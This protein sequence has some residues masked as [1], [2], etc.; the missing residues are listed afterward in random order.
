MHARRDDPAG[1][2]TSGRDAVV[3]PS[4]GEETDLSAARSPRYVAIITDG[5]RRWA[6]ARGLSM[7]E[8]HDA[9]ASTVRATWS[10][11]C[12]SDGNQASNCDAGG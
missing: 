3:D 5:N 8:A 10:G 7:S 9:A 4:G 12:A 11:V 6:R 2:I 1:V